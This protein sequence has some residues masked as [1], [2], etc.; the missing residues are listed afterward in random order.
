MPELTI[1]EAVECLKTRI[2]ESQ[3]ALDAIERALPGC[4]VKSEPDPTAKNTDT[5]QLREAKCRQT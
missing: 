4:V 5:R 1:R 2:L 3:L